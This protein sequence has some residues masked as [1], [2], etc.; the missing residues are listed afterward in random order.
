[1]QKKLIVKIKFMEI[2]DLKVSFTLVFGLIVQKVVPVNKNLK[3]MEILS[4]H[5]KALFVEQL[6]LQ[7]NLK[8]K[9]GEW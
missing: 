7:I 4:F 3:F 6:Y 5:G 1:M 8:T 2:K 9:K